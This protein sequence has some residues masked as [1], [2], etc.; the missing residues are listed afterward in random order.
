MEDTD[1][2]LQAEMFNAVANDDRIKLQDAL[3]RG[4]KPDEFFDDL[5]RVSS[6]NI[7]QIAC[8]KDRI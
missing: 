7:L 5:T 8:E 4:A 6:K 1:D 2:D 3:T